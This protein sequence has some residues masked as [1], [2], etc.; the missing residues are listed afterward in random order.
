MT[1]TFVNPA[2]ELDYRRFS[3]DAFLEESLE[4]RAILKGAGPRSP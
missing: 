2:Q 4:E 3:N 1:P